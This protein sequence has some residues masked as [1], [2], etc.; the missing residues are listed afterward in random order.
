M[1]VPAALSGLG[2]TILNTAEQVA[3]EELPLLIKGLIDLWAGKS[4]T[5]DA[6]KAAEDA[7]DIEVEAAEKAKLGL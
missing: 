7:T 3:V 4:I 1:N 2:Q 5:A 6:V